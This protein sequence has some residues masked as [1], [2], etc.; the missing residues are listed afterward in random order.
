MDRRQW[1]PIVRLAVA[2]SRPDLLQVIARLTRALV[3]SKAQD[4]AQ[5]KTWLF[6]KKNVPAF[7]DRRFM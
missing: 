1:L 7:P 5:Y 2:H 4:I 6:Y 3:S